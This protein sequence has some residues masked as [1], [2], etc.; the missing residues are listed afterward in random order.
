MKRIVPIIA[1]CLFFMS[2]VVAQDEGRLVRRIVMTGF[3]SNT[4]LVPNG[5]VLRELANSDYSYL[6]S[7]HFVCI[8]QNEYSGL[9]MLFANGNITK[10]DCQIRPF[11]TGSNIG[12]CIY[13]LKNVRSSDGP[14]T[15]GSEQVVLGNTNY[16]PCDSVVCMSDEDYVYIDKKVYYRRLFSTYISNF[17]LVVWPEKYSFTMS[18][19]VYFKSPKEW[20]YLKFG[21]TYY[22][23][24]VPN[25][26]IKP[27]YYFLYQEKSTQ[28]TVLVID[29]ME[30]DLHG[31]YDYENFK[32]KYSYNGSHWMAVGGD[33]FWV[34]GEL[35]SVEGYE[36]CDF[37]VNDG[38][39]YMY[40]AFKKGKDNM[41]EVVVLDGEI[42]VSKVYVGYFHLNANQGL[43]FHFY[44]N[45]RWF[46]YNEGVIVDHT[47]KFNFLCYDD[48]RMDGQKIRLVASNGC[49]LDYVVGKEGVFIDNVKVCE[50]IPCQ[51]YYD[52]KNNVFRWNTIELLPQGIKRLVAYK[53]RCGK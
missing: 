6:D 39:S 21:D 16:S 48:D 35:K 36:I 20:K 2:S 17:S 19:S 40:K 25:N 12:N 22:R 26:S 46:V 52:E 15:Y 30:V 53:Y 1:V 10:M 32:L 37:F 51:V 18:D 4:Q 27:H 43:K 44:S 31:L 33:R 47:E 13:V 23:S 5:F 3:D 8:T 34:D 29:G 41:D 28:N 11:V 7:Q 38:G 9:N 24:T 45:G 50:T 14:L 42:V 49:C